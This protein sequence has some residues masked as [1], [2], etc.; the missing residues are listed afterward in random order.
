MHVASNAG[1]PKNVE[2]KAVKRWWQLPR[3]PVRHIHQGQ[4]IEHE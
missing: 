3:S 1:A 4:P 2:S